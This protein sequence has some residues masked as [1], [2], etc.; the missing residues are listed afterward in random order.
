LV[1]CIAQITS[2]GAEP[3]MAL[4]DRSIPSLADTARRNVHVVTPFTSLADS[5]V[6]D[7]ESPEVVGAR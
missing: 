1:E 3:T 7:W 4:K 2:V 6:T 5:N